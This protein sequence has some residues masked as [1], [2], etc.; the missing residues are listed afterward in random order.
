MTKAS[1]A[2]KEFQL[3]ADNTDSACTADPSVF[4]TVTAE[5]RTE[6][7]YAT[8]DSLKGAF[9]LDPG[10]KQI[11]FKVINLSKSGLCVV[12]DAQVPERPNIMVGIGRLIAPVSISWMI[13]TFLSGEAKYK[14][15]L[16]VASDYLNFIAA[17]KDCGSMLEDALIGEHTDSQ[18]F[19]DEFNAG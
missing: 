19:L 5:H 14:Y 16:C 17:L 15:G 12:A 1:P 7:R 4:N 13:R 3:P 18:S 8:D 10:A 9:Y 6:K 11:R 2:A